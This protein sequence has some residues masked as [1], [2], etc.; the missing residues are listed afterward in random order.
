MV[1]RDVVWTGDGSPTYYLGK[2]GMHNSVGA[3]SETQYIYGPVARGCFAWTDD[4]IEGPHFL[5]VGLGLGYNEFL[6]A[7]EATTAPVPGARDAWTCLSY[8]SEAFLRTD[9][10]DYV[11]ERPMAEE[12]AHLYDAICQRF[13]Q[14]LVP[15]ALEI[16]SHAPA[17]D[18]AAFE[19]A[20]HEAAAGI[21]AELRRAH[22]EERW[23]LEPALCLR[24]AE[25]PHRI[26]GFLW[27]AF[28]RKTSPE[29]WEKEA[30]TAFLARTR[31]PHALFSTY[32]SF[33]D[34]H[35]AL[36][37]AGFTI[38]IRPGFAEKRESCFARTDV[39]APA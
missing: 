32:A 22:A 25:V 2:E 8:E 31:A 7:T 9:F 39:P 14:G 36:T 37:A 27:D 21:R 18:C 34:L 24:S 33:G 15:P 19:R 1:S 6:V 10:L 30:L 5:S 28:S 16:G 17:A 4:A 20:I 23:R 29:L 38:E 11:F 3:Y 12:K 26:H 13:A 35:R